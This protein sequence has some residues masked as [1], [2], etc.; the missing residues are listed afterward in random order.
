LPNSFN[1]RVDLFLLLAEPHLITEVIR[2]AFVAQ[3]SFCEHAR[4][5][6]YQYIYRIRAAAGTGSACGLGAS[7]TP[8]LRELVRAVPRTRTHANTAGLHASAA[9]GLSGRLLFGRSTAVT[10]G[11]VRGHR[12]PVTTNNRR[13]HRDTRQRRCTR[14]CKRSNLPP[15]PRSRPAPSTRQLRT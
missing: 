8:D 14:M 10:T 6:C 12:A 7:P 1:L 15:V 9:M 11:F 4:V 2:I 5:P 3:A 13:A